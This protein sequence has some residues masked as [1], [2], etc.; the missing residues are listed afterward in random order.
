MRRGLSGFVRA[1]YR[2]STGVLTTGGGDVHAWNVAGNCFGHIA[3]GDALTIVGH[4]KISP[5]QT[6][7]SP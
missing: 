7:T 5:A 1:T 4:Y 3:S 6:I 2:N